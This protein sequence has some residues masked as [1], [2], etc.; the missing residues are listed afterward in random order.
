[1]T[2]P[3]PGTS[4]DRGLPAP[5]RTGPAGPWA[6]FRADLAQTGTALLYGTVEQWLPAAWDPAHPAGLHGR[7]RER[8]QALAGRPDDQRRFAA[9]RLLLRSA[10]ATA[11]DSPLDRVELAHRPGGRPYVRGCDQIGISLSHTRE[12]IVAGVTRRGR[13]GVD[14]ELA[15]RRLAGTGSECRA[16]TP[17]ELAA[18]GPLGEAQRNRR[19]VGLW[20]LKEAYSK[21]YG[22]GLRFGFTSFGFAFGPDG[23]TLCAPDGTPEGE[24]DW[25]FGTF[26][27]PG[28]YVMSAAVHDTGFGPGADLSARTALDEGLLHALLAASTATAPGPRSG[29]AH[30]DR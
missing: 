27:L 4:R 23:P 19:L 29:S 14:V 2:G 8:Y 22:Q 25:L 5:L 6:R 26:P 15:D 24:R 7:D 3:Q 13:I 30:G 18:L 1:M 9:S 21:A 12:L 20:T 17:H 16:C 28:G 11:L 10:A